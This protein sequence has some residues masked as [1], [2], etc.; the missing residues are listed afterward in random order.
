MA[1]EPKVI[2]AGESHEVAL[3]HEVLTAAGLTVAGHTDEES[4]VDPLGPSVPGAA[5]GVVAQ[6]D[7]AHIPGRIMT[8]RA[9]PRVSRIVVLSTDHDP[10]SLI[11]AVGAGADGWIRPDMPAASLRRAL[12]AIHDG[13]SGFSRRHVGFLVDAIRLAGVIPPPDPTADLTPRERQIY[14]DLEAGRST[15]EI[16][17]RLEV[18]EATVRW[19]S[20]RLRRKVGV[21][22]NPTADMVGTDTADAADNDVAIG[23]RP[24]VHARGHGLPEQKRHE[25]LPSRPGHSST[26]R[27]SANRWATLGRAELRVAMLV[28]DGLTN[29]EIADRLFVSKHTVDSH[30]KHAFAKLQVRSRVDL[31]RLVLALD[32]AGPRI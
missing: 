6:T 8:L 14:S 27:D 23:R 15:K 3:V 32:A 25:D 1:T 29:Q 19:H 12:L 18:S 22:A 9:D 2:I 24:P 26:R 10:E 11:A 17:A 20:A 21:G 13:E 4:G 5:I 28:A 16:A 7:A 31:T 30:L